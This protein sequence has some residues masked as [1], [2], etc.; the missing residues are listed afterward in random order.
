MSKVDKTPRYFCTVNKTV[1][2][3]ISGVMK[4]FLLYAM[5]YATIVAMVISVVYTWTYLDREIRN[6]EKAK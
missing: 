5:G 4:E 2:T 1:Q 3:K 6:M